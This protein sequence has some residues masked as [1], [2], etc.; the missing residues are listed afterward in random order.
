MDKEI[1]I[2]VP[3]EAAGYEVVRAL[4][5]LDDEG[6]IELYSSTVI[7]KKADG[8]MEIKD[9]RH[10]RGAWGTVLGLSTGALI[11]LLA[12]PVGVAVGATIGGAA[13][14]GGDLAYSG[15]AGDFVH[16]V[17]AR[18]QP[19]GYAVCASVWEDWMA[20][21]DVAVSPFGATVFRQATDDV[22]V[23]Q[24]RA[25]MQAL[26]E[27]R[28]HL[29]AEIAHAT[30]QAKGKL[31]AR[32]AELRAKQAA[33][34]DRLQKRASKLEESW[35]AKIASIKEKAASAKAEVK[36]RHQQH[37]EKLARFAAAQR[38]AFHQLF[39]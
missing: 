3:T 19:G 2:V 33:Q 29:E 23:A 36:S 5:A 1:V 25:E 35:E 18:L 28:A 6:S 4:K 34:R 8:A 7:G 21:I 17:S 32:R 12:G 24:I 22:V 37:V 26:G 15:F 31:E 9:T 10:L 14:L 11:G 38:D 13:G 20:P 39:A 30:G 16:D 27:E